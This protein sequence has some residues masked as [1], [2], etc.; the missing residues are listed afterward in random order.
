[1]RKIVEW[2]FSFF[3]SKEAMEAEK[4][5]ALRNIKKELR[6]YKNKTYFNKLA[7]K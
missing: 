3:I 2:F 4:E 6:D 7:R 5:S 1:M